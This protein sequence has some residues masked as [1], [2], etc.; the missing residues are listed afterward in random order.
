M[1]VFGLSLTS[2]LILVFIFWLGTRF[3]DAFG[4]LPLLGR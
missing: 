2:I 4:N 3:P 1:K